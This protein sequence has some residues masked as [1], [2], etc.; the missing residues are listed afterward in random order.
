[1]IDNIILINPY[2]QNR[3]RSIAQV[4]IGPPLGL[5]YIAAVLEQNGYKVA[6]IDANAEKLSE[7]EVLCRIMHVKPALIGLTA[8]TPTI[9]ICYSIAKKIKKEE[10]SI[11]TVIGGVHATSLPKE[12]LNECVDFDFLVKGEGEFTLIEL[13]DALSKNKALSYI[14]GLV[15]R[16][17]GKIVIN[18]T[19]EAVLDLD[20]FPFPSRQLL[21]NRLYKTIDSDRMTCIIAM[22]GCAARCIYCAVEEVAG[23]KL[24]RRSPSNVIKEIESCF[25]NYG[26]RFIAFLDDTFTFDKMWVHKFCDE[27]REAR[28]HKYVKW[29]C[30]TRVDNVDPDLLKHMKQAGCVRVE[31]GIES[32]S[33]EILDLLKKGITVKQIRDAFNMAKEAGLSNLGF[34]MLNAPGET[35]R[36]V[37]ETKKLIMDLDPDF[38][39]LSF[40]TPYPGTELFEIC[41]RDNLLISK[42]W[43]KYIFLNHQLIRNKN[44]SENKLKKCMWDIQRSFYLRPRYILRT[45]IYMLR[46]IGTAKTIIW[47]GMNALKLLFKNRKTQ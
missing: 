7:E 46:N 40:A 35:I 28:F 31:F 2:Y 37:A 13:V 27:F 4:S 33:Q 32:G 19:R 15:Y 42:D 39:Q 22:R 44:L 10:P 16:E 24:R 12:T 8:V 21:P 47:A 6:I 29:S 17:N 38:L 20:I 34:A 3:I 18:D 1:M 14:K 41:E 11:I 26:V 30:L 9:H 5:A 36:T 45:L 43:S 23:R 25:Y